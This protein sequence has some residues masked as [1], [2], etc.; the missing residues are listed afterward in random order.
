MMNRDKILATRMWLSLLVEIH[1]YYAVALISHTQRFTF[2]GR[3]Y[4]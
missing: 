3:K 2:T 4:T 1:P